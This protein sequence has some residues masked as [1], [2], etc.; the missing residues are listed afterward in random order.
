SGQLNP[1][2]TQDIFLWGRGVCWVSL[3]TLPLDDSKVRNLQV[4]LSF[5][6]FF[7][8]KRHDYEV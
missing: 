2:E 8:Y 5:K 7:R 3:L 4:L 6:Y 1:G